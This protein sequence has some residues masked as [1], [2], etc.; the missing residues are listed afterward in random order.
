[1]IPLQL[2][3]KNFLSY[4]NVT[5]D[6][7]GLHT[8]CICGANGAG[9]SSL[10]EAIAWTVWG[11]SRTSSDED[12]IHVSKDYVRTDFIFI[13]H[14]QVYRIIRS[15]QRNR[16]NSLDFQIKSSEGFRALSRKGIKATQDI[17]T[18]TLKLDYETFIN[19]AYLRQGRADEFMLRRPTER[20]KVLA[21]LLKLDHYENLSI[22]AREIARQYKGKAEQIKLNLAANKTKLIQEKSIKIQKRTIQEDIEVLKVLQNKNEQAFQVIKQENINRKSSLEKLLWNRER[23]KNLEEEIS[24]SKREK[25][26]LKQKIYNHGKLINQGEIVS[27]KY[28]K[29]LFLRKEEEKLVHKFKKFQEFN[30]EKQELE[31]LFL[32]KNNQLQ[33]RIN[34]QKIYLEQL[35]KEEKE[36]QEKINDTKDLKSALKILNFYSQELK[37]L[38]KLQYEVSPLLKKRQELIH[39]TLKVKIDYKSKLEQINIL[40]SN[41]IA[42]LVIVPHKRKILCNLNSKI[43]DFENEKIYH[44]QIR[45]KIQEKKIAQGKLFVDQQNNIKEIDKSRQKIRD[46]NIS[47]SSCPLCEQKLNKI[48]RHDVIEKIRKQY[49]DIKKQI[50]KTQ[51]KINILK[52]NTNLFIL[53]DKSLTE[54]LEYSKKIQQRFYQIEMHLNKS[55]EIEDKLKSIL[56]EKIKIEKLIKTESFDSISQDS[57]KSIEIRLKKLN[58]TEKNHTLVRSRVDRWRWAEIE[59]SKV[60]DL[61]YRQKQ[62]FEQKYNLIQKINQ[63]IKQKNRLDN[64]SNL[65]EKIDRIE[66]KIKILNYDK[67]AHELISSYIRSSQNYII[68]YEKLQNARKSYS[69]LQQYLK[70]A[71]DR[72]KN[73]YEEQ[74]IA[75]KI[76][77]QLSERL[78]VT[79]NYDQEITEIPK[80]LK[81]QRQNLDQL[82]GQQGRSEQAVS[83]FKILQNER[84]GLQVLHD[85]TCKQY[86]IYSELTKAFSKNGIQ[87]LM[88]ENVLPQLEA[89]TNKILT[90]LTG[91][92]LHIQ[93]ITQKLGK[94]AT[95]RKKSTKLIDTLDI[96]IAD[97]DGTRIYETYSGGEAFRINFS[98][99]LALAKLLAQ[100]SGASLETL[101]IDEGFGTQDAEGCE[102]LIAAI[103]SIAPDFSCILI[104]TH[105]PQF[106]EAFQHRIEISKTNQGSQ[107]SIIN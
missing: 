9:K 66:K 53:K 70:F 57:L 51:E 7:R 18:S 95:T 2:T 26:E 37:K 47:H 69:L 3:L 94:G 107:I 27:R 16:S 22:K 43:D 78:T 68:D 80:I 86:R 34:Q 62:I 102:R 11:Q 84:R 14:Q 1:M 60:N 76:E 74:N 92:K 97:I 8:V 54:K 81:I 65:K 83:E 39:Q 72:L 91:N 6:F 38:D 105:M 19:S 36:L 82:F 10:L 99:R 90:R 45:N 40:E 25:K 58:Y 89:E 71:E 79:K 28:K 103:N 20:K 15:R 67:S 13:C 48:R 98:V 35:E 56:K 42:E 17:I 41:Y 33:L 44:K 75:M 5:L 87:L 63:L 106:Q 31:D 100:R 101:I 88:I 12:I 59:N 96:I 23:C 50:Y 4:Q 104:V 49:K 24:K 46:L 21:D 64:I 85:N 77:N 52:Q 55:A 73:S 32:D 93:F 30:K 61:L 29:F